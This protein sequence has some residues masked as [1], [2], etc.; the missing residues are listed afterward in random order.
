MTNNGASPSWIDMRIVAVVLALSLGGC[1]FLTARLANDPRRECPRSIPA[2]DTAAAVVGFAGMVA[3]TVWY[4]GTP[5][6]E[7]HTDFDAVYRGMMVTT[8]LFTLLE[9]AQAYYGFDVAAKCRAERARLEA[10]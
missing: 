5:D 7:T 1:S 4:A 6:G 9:V 8:G 10:R 2:I 3:A